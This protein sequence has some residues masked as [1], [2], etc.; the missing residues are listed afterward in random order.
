MLRIE[1]LCVS[2]GK[3][4]I[5]DG[6]SYTFEDG[7]K[8]AIMGASGIGKTTLLNVIA[9]T[10]KA[11]GGSVTSSHITLS[12]IFQ[13]P[14]LFPWLTALEN[15]TLVC[16]DADKAKSILCELISDEGICEKYPD[17]LSG[18]MKQRVAIARALAFE[19]DIVLMDEPFKGLDAELKDTVRSFV[20]DRLKKK[21]VI[22]I[23]HDPDDLAYCDTV[24]RMSGS[25]VTH[26]ET[27]LTN[28]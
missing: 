19:S 23:T 28:Q 21:T 16:K 6:L 10:K 2:Y 17:E 15:V 27:E 25:P 22:L 1:N 4:L 13:E 7:V 20:F 9:K 24:L 18:G 14:R 3:S 26:F 8:Y 12:Y 11:R 5:I